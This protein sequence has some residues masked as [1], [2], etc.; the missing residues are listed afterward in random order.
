MLDFSLVI[1]LR[2][3]WTEAPINTWTIS[4]EKL[5]VFCP[6]QV[7]LPSPALAAKGTSQLVLRGNGDRP[8]L[9]DTNSRA[10]NSLSPLR[11]ETEATGT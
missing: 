1:T 10:L 5:F 9:A 2:E 3:I 6:A 11:P 4:K 7:V 8:L